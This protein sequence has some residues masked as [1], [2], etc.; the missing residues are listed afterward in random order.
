MRRACWES[1]RIIT[2]YYSATD[3]EDYLSTIVEGVIWELPVRD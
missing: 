2:A 3:P 1:G